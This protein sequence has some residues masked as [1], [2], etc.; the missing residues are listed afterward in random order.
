MV[1]ALGNNTG[2]SRPRFKLLVPRF[3]FHQLP[4][5]AS[6]VAGSGDIRM[7]VVRAIST[8]NRSR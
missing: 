4:N 3:S 8:S 2:T 7:P 6:G 5:L 1:N